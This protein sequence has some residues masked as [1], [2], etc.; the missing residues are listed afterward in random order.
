MRTGNREDFSL[1]I[2]FPWCIKKCPYCDFNSH[3]ALQ[4]I[5]FDDYIQAMILDYQHMIPKMHG[6]TLKSIF[7][8]GGTPSLFPPQHMDRLL[9]AIDLIT[10]IDD[11]EITLE[12]N[13][14]SLDLSHIPGYRSSGIN[15]LS[16]GVQSFN[17]DALKYLGRIHSKN[18]AI[19][20]IDTAS[21]LF[22]RINI[23]IMFGL[24]QQSLELGLHDIQTACS[25][26]I[27][28]I[29]WYQLTIEP[30]T[31]FAKKT[32]VLPKAEHI[33]SLYEQGIEILN[34]HHYRQYEISA[35]SKN[36]PSQH[37]VNYWSGGDYIGIGAGA[38]SKW[39][40]GDD[41]ERW[42][43]W[44]TPKKYL[45]KTA[46]TRIEWHAHVPE[47]ERMLEYFLNRSR[48]SGSVS[49]SRMAFDSTLTVDYIQK[50]LKPLKNSL[51]NYLELS[52]DGI[53]FLPNA[54][55]FNRPLLEIILE[56]QT[57]HQ[58]TSDKR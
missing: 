41:I 37:N 11:I 56:E 53:K 47:S 49:W 25:Y 35:H 18:D 15:R 31:H 5:P 22:D 51:E 4:S 21:E 54:M 23:D 14:G 43:L 52:E 30:N 12:A 40:T 48:M 58:D 3:V 29:S 13:P 32:P 45:N 26:N 1:Y 9:N 24:P 44:R 57:K 7:L 36:Q 19:E 38:H 17:D 6:R 34:H 46:A 20:A 2:H 16:L 50:W 10:P 42:S 27:E 55:L 8:G 33:E 28:H 39:T